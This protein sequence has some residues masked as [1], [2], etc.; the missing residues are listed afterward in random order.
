MHVIVCGQNFLRLCHAFTTWIKCLCIVYKIY[1]HIQF[2]IKEFV[3][4]ISSK[5]VSTILCVFFFCY[6]ITWCCV[7]IIWK[8]WKTFQNPCETVRLFF[9]LV[10]AFYKL[11]QRSSNKCWYL[12]AKYRSAIKI[13]LTSHTKLLE[14]LKANIVYILL[15]FQ[16]FSS[17]SLPIWCTLYLRLWNV[18]LKIK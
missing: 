4:I 8:C 2:F 12:S 6:I 14:E 17:L 5:W 1:S 13:F 3:C 9:G 11:R 15:N 16:T 10:W 7:S 18:L